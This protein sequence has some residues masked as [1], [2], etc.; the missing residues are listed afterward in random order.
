MANEHT[1]A[2]MTAIFTDH[3]AVAHTICFTDVELPSIESTEAL[4]YSTNCD[5][6]AVSGSTC[7]GLKSFEPADLAT[8]GDCTFTCR[9]DLT[10]AQTWES[11]MNCKGDLVITSLVTS[12]IKTYE[13]LYVKSVDY[14]SWN[15]ESNGNYN[16]IFG[17]CGTT[18]TLT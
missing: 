2:A 3:L 8:L 13:D 17:A 14:D 6:S 1:A 5:F 15:I 11:L 16:L 9:M 18:P 10:E 4:D 12:K 7:M